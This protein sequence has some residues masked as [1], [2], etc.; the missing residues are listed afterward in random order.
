VEEE[1]SVLCRMALMALMDM[2]FE[3]PIIHLLACT[4]STVGHSLVPSSEQDGVAS[5]GVEAVA[6]SLVV[7]EA[8]VVGG[9]SPRGPSADQ[10]GDWQSSIPHERP[11]KTSQKYLKFRPSPLP[12]PRRGEGGGEGD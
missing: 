10:S 6:E 9:G 3:L 12:S 11:P 2:A 5:R 7:G 1:V 4:H 8:S